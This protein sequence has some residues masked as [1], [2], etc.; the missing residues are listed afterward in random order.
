MGVHF[1]SQS[2]HNPVP[3]CIIFCSSFRGFII[4]LDICIPAL[5]DAW[6]CISIGHRQASLDSNSGLSCVLVTS[7]FPTCFCVFPQVTRCIIEVL[8]NA[9]SKS[10]IP[11]VTPECRQVLKNGNCPTLHVDP[12]PQFSLLLLSPLTCK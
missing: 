11:P 2:K 4:V 1:P 3:S 7:T 12:G 9:L 5:R 8:S 10:S 6:S